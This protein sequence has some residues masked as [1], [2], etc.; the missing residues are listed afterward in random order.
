MLRE[1]RDPKVTLGE[2]SKKL[3]EPVERI[4]DALEA[5]GMLAGKPAYIGAD[6]YVYVD[7]P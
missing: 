1:Q 5:D 6:G 4:M 2:L 3:D 7:P